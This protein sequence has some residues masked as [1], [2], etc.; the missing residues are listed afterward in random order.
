M[1]FDNSVFFIKCFLK[2]YSVHYKMKYVLWKCSMKDPMTYSVSGI[3]T[4]HDYVI[5]VSR[6]YHDQALCTQITCSPLQSSLHG[7]MF[8]EK[9]ISIPMLHIHGHGLDNF[10]WIIIVVCHRFCHVTKMQIPIQFVSEWK[11]ISLPSWVLI[12]SSFL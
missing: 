10:K 12:R 8:V 11:H 5:I 9:C 4:K 3:V 7:F 2:S 1:V 6:V